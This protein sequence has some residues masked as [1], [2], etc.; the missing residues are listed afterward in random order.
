MSMGRPPAAKDIGPD[1]K[2]STWPRITISSPPGLREMLNAIAAVENRPIWRIIADGV[3][4]YMKSLPAE[5]RRLI[6]GL[7][8]R[9]KMKAAK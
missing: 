6:D 7:A 3:A 1:A 4:L 5:D 8:A 2:T 9:A